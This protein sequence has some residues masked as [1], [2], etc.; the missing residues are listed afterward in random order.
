M[1]HFTIDLPD[2]K[3]GDVRWGSVRKLQLNL[4]IFSKHKPKTE[5]KTGYKVRVTPDEAFEL[6]KSEGGEWTK[7]ADGNIPLNDEPLLSIKRAIIE[8]EKE[9]RGL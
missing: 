9:L 2:N 4:N 7:D 5:A 3:Q 6:F 1:G 8:K